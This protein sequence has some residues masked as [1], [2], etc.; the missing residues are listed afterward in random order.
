MSYASAARRRT[1]RYRVDFTTCAK[2]NCQRWCAGARKVGDL[3]ERSTKS[4][5]VP[6]ER[7]QN[8][9]LRKLAALGEIRVMI[10][11]FDAVVEVGRDFPCGRGTFAAMA[12]TCGFSLCRC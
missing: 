7:R 5:P 9:P 6:I 10:A 2:L 3:V 11:D 4:N 12:A 1:A 8:G